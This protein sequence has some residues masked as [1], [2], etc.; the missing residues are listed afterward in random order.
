[1]SSTTFAPVATDSQTI[2][3]I[4][5]EIV[6]AVSSDNESEKSSKVSKSKFAGKYNKFKYF[7]HWF[8]EEMKS[9]HIITGKHMW[10]VRG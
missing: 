5:E 1:M 2:P 8:V 6:E 3:K 9:K 4:L 7:A 10:S